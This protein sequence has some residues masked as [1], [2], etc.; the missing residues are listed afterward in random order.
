MDFAITSLL[1]AYW[2]LNPLILVAK[3]QFNCGFHFRLLVL[4]LDRVH[5][6]LLN[7]I[8]LSKELLELLD[9]NW[10]RLGAVSLLMVLSTVEAEEMA[11]GNL[12]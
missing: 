7:V 9:T 6:G 12:H 3:Y 10:T 2:L 4:L 1:A 11:T 5:P 8:P